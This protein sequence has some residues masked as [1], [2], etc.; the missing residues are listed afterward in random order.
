MESPKEVVMDTSSRI[1]LAL[2]VAGAFAGSAAATTV[3]LSTADSGTINGALFQRSYVQPA[4]TGVIDSFLRVQ[5][6]GTEQGYN[7]SGRPVA[8]DEKTDPNFTRNLRFGELTPITIN[9]ASYFDFLLD[10]N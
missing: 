7:T 4:G 9:G 1:A 6:N 3:D 5:H 2:S 10:T 8:F